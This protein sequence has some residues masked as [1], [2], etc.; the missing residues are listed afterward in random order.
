MKEIIRAIVRWLKGKGPASATLRVLLLLVVAVVLTLLVK[1]TRE[2]AYEFRDKGGADGYRGGAILGHDKFGDRFSSIR[3]LDQGWKPEDSLWFYNTT[4]GSD[5]LPYDLFMEV[6]Q[7]GKQTLFRDNENINLF[8]YLP[9]TATT[10]NP[11]GLPVGFTKDT[12]LKH[13]YLGYTCA[14]CHTAQVNYN[15]VGMRIDGGP[16]SA[17]VDGFVRALAAALLTTQNDPAVLTPFVKRVIARGH[18]RTEQEVIDALKTSTQELKVYN[19]INASSTAY[20]YARLDA[21]GRIYN[22]VLEHVL[23]ADQFRQLLQG[24]VPDASL[25]A[26]LAGTDGGLSGIQRDRIYNLLSTAQ[27]ENLKEAI[28][29]EPNAPVSYPF[30][31]DIPQHDFVQWNGL[32]ANAGLG[33]VGRNAGEVIG[34]FATLDWKRKSGFSISSLITGQGFRTHVS[35]DSSINVHNLR[36]L[37]ARLGQLQSPQWP[38]DLLP[39]IDDARKAAGELLFAQYCSACHSEINRTDPLRRVVAHMSSVDHVGTDDKMANNSMHYVGL[40]GILRNEYARLDV[41]DVL[42]DEHAPAVGLLTKATLGVVA[43]PYPYGNPISRGVNWSYDLIYAFFNNEIK[44]SLKSGEY[45]S[46]TTSSP[47]AS[48]HSYK[49]RPLNGIWATSPYLHNGSVPTLY[50]LLLPKKRPGDPADGEYR[51]DTFMVGS[52]EFDPVHVG[53]KSSGYD[54]F[55]FDTSIPGNSNAGHEYT[56][57]PGHSP[58]PSGA[59][60]PALS[61]EQR[62]EL[63]EYLKSL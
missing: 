51:P 7:P 59:V 13:D 20:G 54:G 23:T 39:K 41:G 45:D 49:A 43:T 46:D 31:W 56:A 58:Q 42:L 55:A 27:L 15:G 38:Q 9:Q 21:F 50:D 10:R 62:M 48:F 52:R 6:E 44:P 1:L 25:N 26:A 19:T 53:L 35:F 29:N 11:D 22:R 63:L 57:G 30:L 28:A 5:L 4:Q 8:G 37:E 18:F 61:A 32:V 17:D 2:G 60:L 47:I 3:Y 24:V 36:R 12:F 14:A 16:S 33:A 40:S 34:V